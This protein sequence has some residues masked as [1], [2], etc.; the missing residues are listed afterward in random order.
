[1]RPQGGL[2][3]PLAGSHGRL[4]HRVAADVL[5]VPALDKVHLHRLHAGL[6][7]DVHRGDG[8]LPECRATEPVHHHQHLLAQVTKVRMRVEDRSRHLVGQLV[9]QRPREVREDPQA[10]L[11]HKVLV[12]R[13]LVLQELHDPAGESLGDAALAEVAP[14]EPE[15]LHFVAPHVLQVGH[16]GGDA[17][18]D[19]GESD[20]GE[21]EHRDGE[22]ALAGVAGAHVHRGR[23]EL[24]QAP[25]EGCEVF[26]V[27]FPVNGLAGLQPV[28]LA[29]TYSPGAYEEPDASDD[30][31]QEQERQQQLHQVDECERV[32]GLD[33]LEHRGHY[34]AELEQPQEPQDT[35]RPGTAEDPSKAYPPVGAVSLGD[36]HEP[37]R[38]HDDEVYGQPCAD[39]VPHHQPC[40][41]DHNSLVVVAEKERLHHV[42]SP[43]EETDPVQRGGEPDSWRVERLEG[44]QQQV[45]TNEEQAQCVPAHAPY[46]VGRDYHAPQ[47][48]EPQEAIAPGVPDTAKP[49]GPPPEHRA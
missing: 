43:E 44:D 10:V 30:V 26:V 23:G 27:E 11:L 6:E 22:G 38:H 39:V 48:A 8:T 21:E 13:R 35:Q 42:A 41:H 46:A 20:Q 28:R 25:V 37:V 33:H 36:G 14:E 49:G 24:R 31:V 17:P 47:A 45:T 5:Q 12:A 9:P 7:H 32:L 15:L 3:H 18:H 19:R 40:L 16:G 4:Q 34:P 29:A 1:M 2:A